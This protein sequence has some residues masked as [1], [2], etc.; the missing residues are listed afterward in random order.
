MILSPLKQEIEFQNLRRTLIFENFLFSFHHKNVTFW[1]QCV[2][3]FSSQNCHNNF[4]YFLVTKLWLNDKKEV[5]IRKPFYDENRNY[6][7]TLKVIILWWK[8][9]ENI[10]K[11]EGVKLQISHNVMIL[12]WKCGDKSMKKIDQKVAIMWQKCDYK[13]TTISYFC[14]RK[15]Q[16][17]YLG[18]HEKLGS[19]LLPP[20]CSNV[21]NLW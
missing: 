18:M 13:F 17:K 10:L 9:D 20:H 1:C 8:C 12:W 14:D 5:L 16:H 15:T 21:I 19:I 4:H 7:F 2:S 11:C 3:T 6:C